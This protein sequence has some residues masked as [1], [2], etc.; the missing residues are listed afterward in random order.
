MMHEMFLLD[1]YY[2][3]IIATV[4][5]LFHSNSERVAG[6]PEQEQYMLALLVTGVQSVDFRRVR[7]VFA[8]GE[9]RIPQGRP[10]MSYVKNRQSNPALENTSYH[11]MT[12]YKNLN[13]QFKHACVCK[14]V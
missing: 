9:I 8:R 10:R 12:F 6:V 14:C 4:L 13:E 5:T 7:C 1:L 11:K 2:Y 3:D